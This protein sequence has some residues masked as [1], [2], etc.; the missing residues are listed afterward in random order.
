MTAPNSSLPSFQHAWL[1]EGQCFPACLLT[2]PA[3]GR[4]L[5]LAS[6][7]KH[8][9]SITASHRL[10][11]AHY[12]ELRTWGRRCRVQLCPPPC[13]TTAPSQP[14]GQWVAARAPGP[15]LLGALGCASPQAVLQQLVGAGRAGTRHQAHGGLMEED[16]KGKAGWGGEMWADTGVMLRLNSR[17]PSAATFRERSADTSATRDP[18]PC[19]SLVFP[20]VSGEFAG[21]DKKKKK[22]KKL[23]TCNCDWP[24]KAGEQEQGT[25]QK[26]GG[27]TPALWPRWASRPRLL[28]QHSSN[29]I[30]LGNAEF[31]QY[32]DNSLVQVLNDVSS[33]E[34]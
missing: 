19:S 31:G 23:L 21:Q 17:H 15:T 9:R 14:H 32:Q 16:L 20:P 27:Q 29:S 28:V 6:S 33:T 26:M 30:K 24:G 25:G 12:P 10:T 18:L 4:Q 5:T 2:P 3:Q 22:K 11:G 1:H 13:P 8:G 7:Q 34:A